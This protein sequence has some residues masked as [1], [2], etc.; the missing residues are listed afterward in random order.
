MTEPAARTTPRFPVVIYPS[1][2]FIAG[3]FLIAVG[4]ISGGVAQGR[5]AGEHSTPALILLG[6]TYLISRWYRRAHLVFEAS[7][8]VLQ[9]H[10]M[11]YCEVKTVRLEREEK[12]PVRML[13][14]YDKNNVVRLAIPVRLYGSAVSRIEATLGAVLPESVESKGDLG[15]GHRIL[16]LWLVVGLTTCLAAL[17]SFGVF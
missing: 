2:V 16:L 8:L 15:A 14:F 5:I 1:P 11:L 12:R 4:L 6:L 9:D 17:E 7:R 3:P 10:I 13:N